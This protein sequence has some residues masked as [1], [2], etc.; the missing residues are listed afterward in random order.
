[1]K[2]LT[3]IQRIDKVLDYF[4]NN[5]WRIDFDILKKEMKNQVVVKN[6]PEL[7]TL[8]DKLQVDRNIMYAGDK[9][10][11]DLWQITYEGLLSDTYEKKKEIENSGRAIA[12]TNQMVA[13]KNEILLV[14]GTWFAGIA[15]VLLLLWQIFIYLYPIH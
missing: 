9:D 1:M 3:P 8:I 10:H 15:A 6:D 14:R 11:T 13:K 12:E 2:D 4:K 7:R 5:P